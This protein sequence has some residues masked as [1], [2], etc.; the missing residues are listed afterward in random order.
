MIHLCLTFSCWWLLLL[1]FGSLLL[2]GL[3]DGL[4]VDDDFTTVLNFWSIIAF[5][6]LLVGLVGYS[7]GHTWS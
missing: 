3:L 1:P 7:I 5:F 4:G 2:S 6:M